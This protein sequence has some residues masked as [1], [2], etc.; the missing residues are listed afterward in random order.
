M[1]PRERDAFVSPTE[2]TVPLEGE[3]V[4][5]PPRFDEKSVQHAQP[6]V[7][8]TLGA[9]AR[10]WPLWVIVLCVLGG[11]VGGVLG[12]LALTFYQ[13]DGGPTA[14]RRMPAD[15]PGGAVVSP[16]AVVEPSPQASQPEAVPAAAVEPTPLAPTQEPATDNTAPKK[17]V[18][19]AE[20]GAD[21]QSELRSALGGWLAATN[22]RDVG[23]QMDFYAPKVE[24]FYLARN[25]SRESVRAEKARLFSRASSVNVEAAP[26]EIRLSPD[27][28]TAV[29]R[30]RK[31]YRIDGADSRAGE[32]LQ[33]LRWRRTDTGWKIVG[34]RDLRVLQ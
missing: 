25:A 33:E 3:R 4:I 34:E 5:S 7:P 29:M 22:Q 21:V 11:V 9:R 32:V 18:A 28:R 12:G 13:R 2:E 17:E 30:F 10:S 19:N 14:A 8:L 26:P 6:A 15:A 23:R 24:A 20:A 27:G 16:A 1:E 31:R